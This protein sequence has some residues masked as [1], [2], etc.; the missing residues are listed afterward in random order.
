M[1]H[2]LDQVFVK[3]I[4]PSKRVGAKL[5]RKQAAYVGMFN[6]Y[7]HST[8]EPTGNPVEIKPED[9]DHWAQ[10]VKVQV[11]NGVAI[12]MQRTHEPT[13]D[14][15]LADGYVIDADTGNDEKGRY[16]LFLICEFKNEDAERDL[17]S[18]A[19]VSIY[20]PPSYV[21]GTRTMYV[22][23]IRHLMLTTAPTIP[24][25]SRFV[26]LSLTP[27]KPTM[28]SEFAKRLAQMFGLTLVDGDTDETI[29][30]KIGG[31]WATAKANV[32]QL[33]AALAAKPAEPVVA[34]SL[35][36]LAVN[37]AHKAR[38]ST[39]ENLVQS[40]RITP[41]QRDELQ[42]VWCGPNGS[43]VALSLNATQDDIEDPLFNNLVAALSLTP[44]KNIVG[45]SVLPNAGAPTVQ[46]NAKADRFLNR[47]RKNAEKK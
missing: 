35:P 2:D 33:T 37:M 27:R 44:A 7:D 8:G 36:P 42:K 25:M 20:Q 17:A 22:R 30:S 28:L 26:A 11:K 1:L 23:P 39:L 45:G 40:G 41:A 38:T 21:D 47:V 31:L 5:W 46:D 3:D 14:P 32:E 12:P 15:E 18:V 9:I 13:T 4:A 24:G 10:S 19:D 29:F 43:T 6:Q 16:S 34:M